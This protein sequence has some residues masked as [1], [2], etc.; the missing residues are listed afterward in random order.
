F[1]GIEAGERT[2]LAESQLHAGLDELPDCLDPVLREPAAKRLVRD[3]RS[4][5]SFH[6]RLAHDALLSAIPYLKSHADNRATTQASRDTMPPCD[7]RADE[8]RRSAGEV[9]RQGAGKSTGVDPSALMPPGRTHLRRTK[10]KS[11]AGWTR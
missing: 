3:Q 10:P 6:A 9:A 4:V 5:D 1:G 8:S 11:R 2:P 7:L